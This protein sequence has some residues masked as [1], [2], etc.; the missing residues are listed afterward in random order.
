MSST[1]LLKRWTSR[2]FLRP[3][4]HYIPCRKEERLV[5]TPWGRLQLWREYSHGGTARPARVHFLRFLGSRGRAE[6]ATLDP[7]DRL[8]DT[9]SEVW[10]VNPPAFGGTSGPA[11]LERYADCALAALEHVHRHAAGV[12]V[13]VCG[14]S[15]GTAAALL[16]SAH[17]GAAG[18]I[19]RNVMP[20][21]ELLARHYAWRTGGLSRFVL[22][23]AVPK[24][25]DCIANAKHASVPAL[26][27]LS[28]E[29]RIS[30]PA[31]QR[32][33][34]A[35][36]GGAKTVLEVAGGHDERRLQPEDELAYATAL[37]R[38]LPAGP[39]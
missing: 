7:G 9:P 16:A 30:P 32:E 4:H 13:W 1:K 29:D 18:A 27:L 24:V 39:A 23:A 6:L 2:A 37:R 14:K 12:P 25:L 10:T 5:G 17:G 26:F 35:A 33:V 38:L 28:R 8:G 34:I 20:L 11:D 36:Y 22:A 31:Y 21:R 3:S 19:L 15:I